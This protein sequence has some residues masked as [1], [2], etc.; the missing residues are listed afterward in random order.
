MNPEFAMP[1]V[2]LPTLAAAPGHP[3]RITP[4]D[5]SSFVRL[6]QC[7]RFLR[8]RLAERAGTRFMD[9]YGVTP[10]RLA[11]LLSLSGREF[12]EGV[13]K[14]IAAKA[15]AVHYAAKYG[16]DHDRPANNA[17]VVAEAKGLAAGRCVVLFQ[18]RLHV[19]AEGW[20][21]RGD[22]DVLR[23][24]RD[25]GGRLTALVADMKSTVEVKVE[26]RL[27]VAYY[28]LM[29]ERLFAAEGVEYAGVQ[30][31]ILFR[32]PA[33]PTTEEEVE[34]LPPLREAAKGWLGLDG[35]L[36]EVVADQEAY[37]RSVRDLV[38]GPEST[39]R[40]VAAADF[41][42][43]PFCLSYK[44]DGCL[45]NEWCMKDSAEREDLSLLAYTTGVEKEAVRRAGVTTI[46][47]LAG[48]KDL[49][50]AGELTAAAGREAVVRQL[51]ATWPVGPRLDE[52]IHR[53]KQFRKSV[54][55]DG[56]AALGYIPG[57]GQSTLPT[58]T[59]TLNPN[60][61]RIYVEAQHDHLNDR[62]W[63]LAALV[64]G[65]EG[66]QAAPD[67]R[68]FV[69]NASDGP[70]TDA[71]QER[72][73]FVAWTRDLVKAA[74][75]VAAPAR[76]APVHFV[77]F[78]RH[79][80]RLMLEALARNFP[81]IL[82]SSPPLYDLLTQLA[83]FDSP[84]AT[85]LSEEV[86]EF[87]NFPMV[88]QS[89]QSL[90]TYLKF[91]WQQPRPFRD[92]FKARVFDYVGKLDIG[93]SSEW[94]TKRS[95][96]GTNLPLEYAYAAWGELPLPN[97]GRGD[98]FADY[99][100]STLEL[101]RAFQERRLEAIEH[102][103]GSLTPNPHVEKTAFTLPDLAGYEDKAGDLAQA[104]R[105]FVVIERH[106][107]LNDWVGT[108]H[109][110]PERRVLMGETLLARYDEADQDPEV[111]EQNRENRRR[112]RRRAELEA[113]HR[114]SRAGGP[115]RLGREQ[116]A[117]CR[118]SQD[119]LRVK[120][121]VETAGVDCD[122]HEAL[123]LSNLREGDRL[124]V[125]PRWAV[126]DRLPASQRRPF[127]PTPKQ[128]MYANRGELGRVVATEKDD[129]GRVLAATVEV[130]LKDSFGGDW[131][132]GFV[133]PA[134][135]R[136]LE[137]GTV[138]TLDPCPNDWYGYWC[139]VVVEGLCKGE[140]NRLFKLLNDPVSWGRDASGLSG[141]AKFLAGLFAFQSEGLL[142]DFEKSKRT[143]IGGYGKA[144]V[145]QTQGPPG[146]GK[147]YSTAFAVFARL[148]GAMHAGRDLRVFVCCKTHAATDV[149]VRNLLD[150]RKKLAE[151]RAESPGLFDQFLDPRLLDV[152]CLRV[153]PHDPPPDG[154]VHL[155][156]DAEKEDGSPKNADV[157]QGHRWCVVGVTPGGVYSL[158][159][160]KWPKALFG[161]GLCDV[162]VLDEASQMNLPEAMMAAL[163]LMADG[164]VIV[165]GDHRQ[166]PPI[167]KHDW[168][169]ETRRTFK[170]YEVYTSLFD[171]L[172]Q[173]NPPFIQFGESF[174]LH[175]SMAAFLRE[176]VYRHD[177]IDYF[178]R[179]TDKLPARQNDD[180]LIAA[181]LHPDY[182][183]IVIV[184][185]EEASQVRNPYEQSLI[186][187]ILRFLAS[188][189]GHGLDGEK[190]VGVV[191]PHRAQRAAL[192]AAFPELCILDPTSGLP[193]R[194]AIDTVER[195]QG[196]ER[197]VIMVS[198]TESD[199]GYL[200]ASAGFLL[201]PR[202][203]TVALSRAK[204]K[205]ILV[206]SR[207]IFSLFSPDEETFKNALLWKNL[208]AT[209]CPT[210]LWQGER[211][212]NKVS[213]WGGK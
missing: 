165:V 84:V 67:R 141:Q 162:L 107:S 167:V 17:E 117:E 151:L 55:R 46:E 51:A 106:V 127:T 18:A 203:L 85:F 114:A 108:R 100:H 36:L 119:G 192:Q 59:P 27:Q 103:A 183:L 90:A 112:Q 9:D 41:D 149:L 35:V 6:E 150:V 116:A 49:S 89:L 182:P 45:Y 139:N 122:L 163:P 178:S 201:D 10:Q 142:H 50:P 78:D 13:E 37:R 110:P 58:S 121:R 128:L 96:F 204:R 196:G 104:L 188:A 189:E 111:A 144:P 62:L 131:S 72:D 33:S 177:G 73:L 76:E 97:A 180:P 70:P 25:G 212:S 135:S 43:L 159:K 83:G 152:P 81:P 30:T 92:A 175:A 31:G 181:A 29:L 14:D 120:L 211:Q 66:G 179:K 198:A 158:L 38:T 164:Q 205:M 60:L 136:P 133:F 132:R 47:A 79:E 105:E 208:L 130:E 102:V 28:A 52:L 48:L 145:L 40:R 213:V 113:A 61:I 8:F 5:V 154:V 171:T 3:L 185:G 23:L 2:P 80:Q 194:S 42:A 147:S 168:E 195:F 75:E 129:A 91:D 98:E 186:E 137:D 15:R 140:P 148:Q 176:E 71:G 4:T 207:S 77:F 109:A 95:R 56:T 153:A 190:G 20:L 24:A 22:V 199:R 34:V 86:R 202:R 93:G 166:M 187:P 68:R 191:V 65:S 156:K 19:E 63:S 11:P 69:I 26:H 21:I 99:R 155:L 39:A 82:R 16:G 134:I 210:L 193:V 146:T 169:Q 206:A 1:P 64:V 174:R 74:V 54:R 101:L 115:F 32:P 123:A 184:H 209:A 197:T 161:H 53:A 57:K 12:E 200:L 44:C 170:Q 118:W 7:E 157:I 125:H 94:Y 138:Y 126:D 160:S 87:K 143:F 88:C 172:R 173:H 124:V